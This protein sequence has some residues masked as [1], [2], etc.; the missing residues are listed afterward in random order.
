MYFLNLKLFNLWKNAFL[1]YS[2][3]YRHIWRLVTP[4]TK[5]VIKDKIT[6][7]V[8]ILFRIFEKYA[9]KWK[10]KSQFPK[11]HSFSPFRRNF[12]GPETSILIFLHFYQKSTLLVFY[13]LGIFCSSNFLKTYL[14]EWP[15]IVCRYQAKYAK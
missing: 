11:K 7:R 12:F 1:A 9:K 14:R 5:N 10:F 6:G 3:C 8:N 13:L 4:F 15:I 2:A